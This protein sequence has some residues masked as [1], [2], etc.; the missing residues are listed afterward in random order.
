[1]KHSSAQSR[2]WLDYRLYVDSIWETHA[3]S[4]CSIGACR[5][6]SALLYTNHGVDTGGHDESTRHR[7]V[8]A[9][10]SEGSH[11]SLPSALV[12]RAHGRSRSSLAA[13]TP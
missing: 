3:V 5:H 10:A 7:V 11:L 2:A 1:M 6:A 9:L 4:M 12:L 8:S 13:Q